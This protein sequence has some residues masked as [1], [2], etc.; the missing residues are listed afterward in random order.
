M[1]CESPDDLMHHVANGL[2]YHK[3]TQASHDGHKSRLSVTLRERSE[4]NKEWKVYSDLICG[5]VKN[6]W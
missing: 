5:S 4:G 2:W 3:V 6:A 1:I